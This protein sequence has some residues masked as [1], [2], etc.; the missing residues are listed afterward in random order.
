[1]PGAG[2]EAGREMPLTGRS[3]IVTRTADQATGLIGPLEALGADVLLMPVIAVADPEEWGP[4]D[5]AVAGIA[6]YA[7]IVLTSANGVDWFDERLRKLGRTLTDLDG[8]VRF[9]V[10]GS[11]TAA[12][13]RERGVEPALV[14]DRFRAEG[15]VEAFRALGAP[16]GTRVLI[17][18]AAEAREVLPEELR[19]AGFMVD[20][21]PVYRLVTAL[22]PPGVLE[23]LRAGGVD[24]VT[25]ASGGTARRFG[26]VLRGAGLDPNEALAGVAVASIGPV[27]SDALRELGVEPDVEAATANAGALAQALGRYF[28]RSGR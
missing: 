16:A 3:V 6:S 8:I 10:V 23:R 14:P 28:E 1:V 19:T 15:L 11:A 25:F 7:W 13:L 24:A 22:P 17:L 20:V 21:V 12:R 4:V 26:E 5:K 9:A 27:T 2:H 18:R